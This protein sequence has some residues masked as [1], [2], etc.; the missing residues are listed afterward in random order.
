M[1]V[2]LIWVGLLGL[3]LTALGV[4]WPGLHG[5]FIFDDFPNIVNNPALH[6]TDLS[7]QSLGKSLS[8]L[9][10]GPLGRPAAVISFALTHYAF[11]LDAFAFKA[12]NLLIHIANALLVAWLLKILLSTTTLGSQRMRDWLPIWCAGIWL[13]HPINVVPVL[14]AVQRMTLLAAFFLLLALVF[15]LKAMVLAPNS[16]A[17]WGQLG[18]AW[19]IFWPLSFLSKETGLLL[20]LYALATGWLI[21][22]TPA[23]DSPAKTEMSIAWILLALALAPGLGMFF[24]LG[25]DWLQSAY[26]MRDFTLTERLLTE[27]RVLWFYLAQILTPSYQ[28]YGFFLDDI[29]L[30]SGL[31][32]PWTTLCSILGLAVLAAVGVVFRRCHPVL[33]FSIAW[34]L[35]GHVMEST[36]L[37][38]EI[39][40]EY[41]N[42]LPS[43]GPI[44]AAGYY[45]GMAL[46]RIKSVHRVITIGFAAVLSLLLPTSLTWMRANQW[47]DPLVAT[48]I[49]AAHHPHSA[50]ANHTIAHT[51]F[52]AGYGDANDPIG[53]RMVRYHFEQ[54][55]AVDPVFKPGYLGL[56][57]WAC[58]SGRPVEKQWVN[59]LS[60]RLE[61]T[62]FG[63]KDRELAGDMIKLFTSMPRCLARE[64]VLS[65]FSAASRNSRISLSLRSVFLESA[66]D[67]EL[68][69][70]GNPASA[71]DFY[72]QALAAAPHNILLRKKLKGLKLEPLL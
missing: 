1:R 30:S 39:A 72:K 27:A 24:W 8:G 50:R 65:L 5:G 51:L 52:Q 53:G 28:A 10:A 57:T 56:L 68:L 47:S 38:L 23:N 36:F 15:H 46:G 49:E 40:H 22:Y 63:P 29:P 67:Y 9:A 55:G 59:A 14:L 34:F 41:R 6:I 7:L 54:S 13:L 71:V 43:I 70:S 3:A 12:I 33:T 58:A 61:Q 32:K 69:V 19:L 35:L 64:D 18:V 2:Y 37:P 21:R 16:R 44:L 31:L 66:A 17:R 48:Q 25:Q 42:Y 20:P 4:Y 26:A 45:G 11:G 60:T 62:P